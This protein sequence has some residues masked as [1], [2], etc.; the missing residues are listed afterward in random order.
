MSRKDISAKSRAETEAARRSAFEGEVPELGPEFFRT[1]RIRVGDKIV[2]EATA[3]LTG[4]SAKGRGRPPLGDSAKVQ[5]SLRLSP[6]V[7]DYF[8]A[9][10]AGWQAR[11]DEVLLRHVREGREEIRRVAEKR[12]GYRGE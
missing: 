6:E 2:R 11:I 8:R 7:L 10:G 5:Q 12:G 4:R 1:A 3:T 9:T